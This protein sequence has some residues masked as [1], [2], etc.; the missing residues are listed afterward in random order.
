MGRGAQRGQ[1]GDALSRASMALLSNGLGQLQR[2]L[3]RA[4]RGFLS[5]QWEGHH[6]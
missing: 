4:E 5:I 3:R 1:G 2:I 6:G